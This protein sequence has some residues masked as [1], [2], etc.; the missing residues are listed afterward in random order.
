MAHTTLDQTAASC[1]EP[2]NLLPS[3]KEA[4]LDLCPGSYDFAQGGGPPDAAWQIPRS[5]SRRD[6]L[7]YLCRDGCALWPRNPWAGAPTLQHPPFPGPWCGPRNRA[8]YVPAAQTDGSMP[9]YPCHPLSPPGWFRIRLRIP[10]SLSWR[11][12]GACRSPG[13]RI[14]RLV[15]RISSVDV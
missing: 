12:I 1:Y 5:V 6:L 11:N 14:T 7:S 15:A 2:A 9:R 3:G 8:P 4:R 10:P 13:P